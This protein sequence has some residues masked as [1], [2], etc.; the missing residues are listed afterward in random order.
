MAVRKSQACDECCCLKIQCSLVPAGGRWGPKQ[1]VELDAEETAQPKWLK[2][3]IEV[4]EM[5]LEL[6]T[7]EVLLEHLELLGD[8]QGLLKSQLKE[9]KGL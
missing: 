8:V 1:K 9:L 2:P 3:V 7:Q 4:S 5:R 6:T